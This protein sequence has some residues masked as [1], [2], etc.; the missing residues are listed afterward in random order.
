MH[1]RECHGQ[2]PKA[3]SLLMCSETRDRPGGVDIRC[4]CWGVPGKIDLGQ[5][6]EG[7]ECHAQELAFILHFP[8]GLAVRGVGATLKFT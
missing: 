7:L 2:V 4:S 8:V 5:T 6:V 1:S 3:V